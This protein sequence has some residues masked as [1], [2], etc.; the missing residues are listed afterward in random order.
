MLASW[1]S[2]AL[3]ACDEG[4]GDGLGTAKTMQ[5]PSVSDHPSMLHHDRRSRNKRIDVDMMRS[6]RGERRQFFDR[7]HSGCPQDAATVL[8]IPQEETQRSG[9]Q[10]GASNGVE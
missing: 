5:I 1:A 9:K 6:T 8:S 2:R 10:P 3:P 4:E 7:C